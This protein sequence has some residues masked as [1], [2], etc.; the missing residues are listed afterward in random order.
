MSL[1][2]TH[3]VRVDAGAASPVWL[4]LYATS[5]AP[6]RSEPVSLKSAPHEVAGG[7]F[8]TGGKEDEGGGMVTRAVSPRSRQSMTAVCAG[9]G[10]DDWRKT[11]PAGSE[12]ERRG[13][14]TLPEKRKR[15]DQQPRE[16]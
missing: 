15:P 7:E 9:G 8:P 11:T 16:T 10:R 12:G 6:R 3:V 4:L 14:E 13:H 5:A 2:H 1:L